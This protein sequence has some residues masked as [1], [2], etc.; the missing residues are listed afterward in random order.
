M[1]GVN[2]SAHDF[3]SVLKLPPLVTLRLPPLGLCD[4]IAFN[5]Q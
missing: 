3:N 5:Q 4:V 1:L 2:P